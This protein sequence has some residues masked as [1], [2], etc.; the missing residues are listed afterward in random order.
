MPD[1]SS[2]KYSMWSY[3]WKLLA[4]PTFIYLLIWGLPKSDQ[5][6]RALWLT[7]SA[8]SC[9]NQYWCC[10]C[11]AARDY[12]RHQNPLRSLQGHVEQ[13]PMILRGG[14]VVLG[15]N[16]S[17]TCKQSALTPR[18]S[19]VLPTPFHN[20]YGILKEI[21]DFLELVSRLY[22]RKHTFCSLQLF[23]AHSRSPQ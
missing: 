5:E 16:E 13:P 23:L 11:S 1:I 3:E 22:N 18:Q 19:S 4:L 8:I 2:K 12:I 15:S 10:S 6:T 20:W 9:E 14:K 21:K 7:R 17:V